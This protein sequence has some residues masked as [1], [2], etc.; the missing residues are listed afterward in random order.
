M[1]R[2]MRLVLGALLVLS[3][4]ACTVKY[5]Y[6][7]LDDAWFDRELQRGWKPPM[8]FGFALPNIDVGSSAL[9]VTVEWSLQDLG[10]QAVA[11]LEEF[12]FVSLNSMSVAGRFIPLDRGAIRP[13]AGGGF[14]RSTLKTHWK[15]P[16]YD[17][18]RYYCSGVCSTGFERTLFSAWHPYLVGGVEIY[19]SADATTTLLIEYRKQT[20]RD[21]AFYDLN[22]DSFSAGIRWLIPAN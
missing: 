18:S 20:G 19:G 8:E 10:R 9:A 4:P 21:D 3:L 6:N 5:S 12:D 13:Y 16:N 11:P 7:R 17:R 1:T 22:G 14:G 2:S 15:G